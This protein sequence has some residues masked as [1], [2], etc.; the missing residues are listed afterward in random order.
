[1]CEKIAPFCLTTLINMARKKVNHFNLLNTDLREEINVC[2]V[3]KLGSIPTPTPP[4]HP[5][6]S[7]SRVQFYSSPRGVER[8]FI[9]Q[10]SACNLRE[11][12]MK[13][14][15]R[16]EKKKKPKPLLVTCSHLGLLKEYAVSFH[17]RR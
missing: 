3:L 15:K 1:M 12:I 7:P 4:P 5:S 6:L 9:C 2:P 8:G 11:S 10:T 16:T 17:R 13:V 14:E